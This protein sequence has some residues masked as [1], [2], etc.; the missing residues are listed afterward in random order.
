M[1]LLYICMYIVQYFLPALC[2]KG[3]VPL[4][5]IC[6]EVEQLNRPW[7]VYAM[8]DFKKLH[9]LTIFFLQAFEG[10]TQPTVNAHQSSLPRIVGSVG[11]F[12]TDSC[13][14]LNYGNLG[15]HY[16]YPVSSVVRSSSRYSRISASVAL[17][18]FHRYIS[19]KPTHVGMIQQLHRRPPE[20]IFVELL[21]VLLEWKLGAGYSANTTVAAI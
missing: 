19:K 4:N 16:T 18:A 8:K 12:P 2:I 6:S 11:C 14:S 7:S 9:A 17:S 15:S 1:Y 20:Y 10:L 3:T 21:L 5:Q 13:R